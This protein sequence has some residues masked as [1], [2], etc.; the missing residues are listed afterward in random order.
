MIKISKRTFMINRIVII[1]NFHLF[2]S[3]VSIVRRKYFYSLDL[4]SYCQGRRKEKGAHVSYKNH[5]QL[6]FLPFHAQR[7][8][9]SGE[10]ITSSTLGTDQ[11]GKGT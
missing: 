8:G 1:I 5:I 10:K 2:S 3:V 9:G 4:T 6:V 11:T 7:V